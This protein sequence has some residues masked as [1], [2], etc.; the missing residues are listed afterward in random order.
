[1]LQANLTS[2]SHVESEVSQA[3]AA[4]LAKWL[5]YAAS[6]ESEVIQVRRHFHR[7]PELS[8]EEVETANFVYME[9]LS[10]KIFDIERNVGNGHGI[11][12][13][14]HGAKAGPTIALRADM[15]ALPIAEETDLLF[16][17]ENPGV[18]HA[19]GHDIHTATLLG[20]AKVIQAHRDEFAGTVV[21]IFQ[22]AEEKKPGGAKAIVDAG[23][24]QDVDAV[25][26]LHVDPSKPAGTVGYGLDYGSAASDAFEI[27]IQGQGGHASSPHKAIDSVVI[28]AETIANLQTLVSRVANPVDPLVVTVASVDAGM[29]APNIIA[30]KAKIVGTIRSTSAEGRATIKAHFLQ[31]AEMTAAMHGGSASVT[32]DEGYPAIQNT[33]SIVKELIAA[34]DYAAVFTDIIENTA[35][36][37]AMMNGEDFAYYLEDTAGAYFTVGCDF[38]EKAKQGQASYPLHNSKFVA[39]EDCILNGMS[40][41]LVI[42]SQYLKA[43]PHD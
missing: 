43:V 7:H 39:N 23:Y 4:L 5:K 30:D 20:V 28:A 27:N 32:Y 11:I 12:A 18:M 24:M 38:L 16:K 42:L 13:R 8:F 19:C 22:H 10:A 37:G 41:F 36:T 29:G 40:L 31:I 21:F 2:T 33:T 17:S 15:D 35:A 26:G 9:L 1:M 14:I 3:T 25:F 6:I 34:I